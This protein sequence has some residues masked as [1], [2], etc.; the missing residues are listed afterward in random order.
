MAQLSHGLS[1]SWTAPADI[2]VSQF[3][4]QYQQN[5]WNL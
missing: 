3:Q 2:F 5:G 1:V 4:V